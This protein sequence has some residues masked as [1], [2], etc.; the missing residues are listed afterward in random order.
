MSNEYD[1]QVGENIAAF[2]GSLSQATLASAMRDVGWKWS[3]PTVAAIEKGERPLKI[4][5]AEDLL[6]ILRVDTLDELVS[7]PLESIW[8]NAYDDYWKSLRSL[9]AAIR[10]YLE[11]RWDLAEVAD[12]M[13]AA[14]ETSDRLDISEETLAW[15]TQDVASVGM[16]P[17]AAVI[18]EIKPDA[19]PHLQA[20]ARSDY[21]R[22]Y[23]SMLTPEEIT[24]PPVTKEGTDGAPTDTSE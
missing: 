5:E 20:L 9:Q 7:R 6:K 10:D 22:Y 24:R 12:R 19:G 21:E 23:L 17:S 14:G 4:A 1:R 2:R 3:Q 8:W 13:H 11:A 15:V 18:P 16:D